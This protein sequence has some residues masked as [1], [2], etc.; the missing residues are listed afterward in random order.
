MLSI[1]NVSNTA[2]ASSYYEQTDDYYSQDRSPS[3]WSGKGSIHLNLTGN[4]DP[5]DFRSLLDGKLPNGFEIHRAA[6]GRRGGTDLTFS[7]P[8]SVSM[9]ALLGNDPRLLIAHEN[10]VSRALTYAESLAKCRVTIDGHTTKELTGNLI[11][12]QF[13]HDL[14]RATDPQ[15]HTHCVVLNI[16]QRQDGEW[17]AIDNEP[18][19]RNKMLLGAYYR[20]ELAKEV[21]ALGYNI[22]ITNSDGR[23]ELNQI[24][25][26][27]IEIFSSRSRMIEQELQEQGLNRS[28]VSAQKLQ[29]LALQTR[30][31]KTNIDRAILKFEWDD[32]ALNAGIDLNNKIGNKNN[33]YLMNS[34][35]AENAVD[36]SI[37]NIGERE[38]VFNEI[39]LIRY[40]LEVGVG[41]TDLVNIRQAIDKSIFGGKLIQNGNL[42][43][44]P[45]AQK[46]EQDILNM[47]M[48]ARNQTHSLLTEFEVNKTLAITNLNNGQQHAV[49]QI[50]TTK[51]RITGI[52]GFA[53]T[54]KTTAL[55][56]ARAIAVSQKIKV[57]GLA[58]SASAARELLGS[59][60]KSQT[61]AAFSTK[62]YAGLDKNTL[63][64][65]DEASMVSVGDMHA[66]LKEAENAQARVLLVGDVGQLSAIE[67]GKPFAQLQHRGMETA[68]LD[69]IQRQ[70]EPM[71]KHAVELAADGAV[72]SSL[73]KL[74]AHIVQIEYYKHRHEQ[75][76]A[77]YTALSLKERSETIIVSGTNN[78]R[79]AI[80]DKVREALN[81]SGTGEMV[82][83]LSRKDMTNAQALRT[84][85][86]QPGDVIRANKDYKRLGLSRGEIAQVVN[87][88]EGVVSLKRSDGKKVEWRPTSQP[89]MS[90][91]SKRDGEL[92][93]GDLIR[94]NENDYS[95]G[96]INGDRATVLNIDKKHIIVEKI[97]GKLLKLDANKP[98]HL[99]HGYCQTV[100][101]SQGQ[102]TNRILIE[103]E[104]NSFTNNEKSYYVSISRA[105]LEV[106]IY[107]DDRDLLPETL[108]R[109][110]EKT[111]A[112]DIKKPIKNAYEL[113]V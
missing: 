93:K 67:A 56:V 110:Y 48:S 72:Y 42:F 37:A 2:G 76:A 22:R 94:F 91:Y 84:T 98:L 32:K 101:S 100:H 7:A 19:Y 41:K 47:E 11:V 9:Q 5:K 8:K 60:I 113:E 104:A 10:A 80:N 97:D 61:L 18:F 82:S 87:G 45:A 102:T 77:D 107:T 3:V 44:T 39:D 43:T 36:Y 14:S 16:T 21:Q 59:G 46:M 28:T 78:N 68:K 31:K 90:V 6:S 20:S 95:I 70:L 64:V 85:S 23:F 71:L 69:E 40:A 79:Q 27:Q 50:L 89:D 81:L 62:K 66:L 49:M 24:T 105:R 112:L 30:E 33:D 29:T 25:Q 12:A 96:I 86:Y 34:Q 26:A 52:Q 55:R 63:I 74:A 92:S 51:N 4:V 111:S 38:A 35:D 57:I 13:R 106:K 54:G 65:L 53:G 58:P 15:L 17:R 73:N 1:S 88:R 103:A 99:D 108:A 75:I 83:L 109:H